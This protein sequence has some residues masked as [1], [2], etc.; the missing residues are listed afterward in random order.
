MPGRGVSGLVNGHRVSLVSPSFAAEISSV[1]DDFTA[2]VRSA[3]SDGLTVL[4]LVESGVAIGFLGVADEGRR[5]SRA[6][7]QRLNAGGIEH[8]AL[9]TGDN[10]RTAAA[11]A[12]RAG[13]SAYQA[14][15]AAQDK[16]DAV[17]RLQARY[18]VVAMVGDGVND[19]PAL[20]T[21]DVGIAM[22]AAGSDTAL[23]AADVALMSD[24][25]SA[26]P[27]FF[28]LGRSTVRGDQAERRI[29]ADRQGRRARRCRRRPRQ[30]VARRLRRHGRR[31]SG[32][33]ELDEAA[34]WHVGRNDD[35]SGEIRV[36][37]RGD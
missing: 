24:D 20:A 4:V 5:E 8:T 27:G 15:A 34:R 6:V 17:K 29:L 22:G 9:L 30:H 14:A 21:A 23:E 32:H 19:A 26:L 13:V 1:S 7:V 18:G 11:I 35:S 36:R 28:A 25:L 10:E 3:E 2:R 31:T 37:R 16:V 12:E 33:T